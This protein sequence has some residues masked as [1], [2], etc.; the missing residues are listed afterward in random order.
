MAKYLPDPKNADNI[1]PSII[2]T[3]PT[4]V[5]KSTILEEQ[6]SDASPACTAQTISSQMRHLPYRPDIDG[7]RT[8]AV[9]LVVLFHAWPNWLRG[10]FIGVD[11]FFVIS[12]FLISSIILHDIDKGTYSITAFYSRRIRRIFPALIL[13]ISCTFAFGWFVMLR[14]EFTSLSKHSAS[15]AAFI[16]NLTYWEEAGYFDSDSTTKPL[17]HL[18]SLG[19]EEQFYILWPLFIW[20]LARWRKS[21]AKFIAIS[22][23]VSFIY[24]VYATSNTPSA[25]YF[26]PLSRFWELAAGGLCACTYSLDR[27]RAV[28]QGKLG[29]IMSIIGLALLA[30]A[31]WKV[32]NQT[33]FPGWWA[34]APVIGTCMLLQ[35]GGGTWIS[36]KLLARPMMVRLGLVSYPFY[37]WHWPLLSFSYIVGGERPTAMVKVGMVVAALA[38]AVLTYIAIERPVQRIQSRTN[39]V[40][41]L[42]VLMTAFGL[43]SCASYFGLLGPRQQNSGVDRYLKALNDVQFPTTQMTPIVYH[44]SHFQQLNG[45]GIGS[46][47]F[48]GDSVI[49]QYGAYATDLLRKEPHRRAKVLFATAG[50]C[51]PIEG[52]IRL[53]QLKFMHCAKTTENGMT[54]AMSSEVD[55]VVFGASWYGYFNPIYD[56]MIL[57]GHRFPSQEAHELAYQQIE[58]SLRRLVTAGK[59]VYFLM[60]PPSGS[61]FDPRSM[62]E[63]SRFAEMQV[64]K[65]LSPFN[66]DAYEQK[67]N[68]ARIR[69]ISLAKNSGA[70]IIY[71][72]DTLCNG[73]L[74]PVIDENGEPIYTDSVHIRPKFSINGARYLEPTLRSPQ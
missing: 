21:L 53:P 33:P 56:E 11:I 47:I 28:R 26:S 44:G 19:V 60:P 4:L 38:L 72:T 61:A 13:V 36:R 41:V 14:T 52:A 69:L 35:A 68:A 57:N 62:I 45:N 31:A 3:F 51:P 43:L 20:G 40:R 30:I 12:G 15:G 74:C 22:L 34:A 18:W 6:P 8:I 48:L 10:G 67:N 59:R 1:Q 54:L 49:E 23:V 50:G 39:I 29:E 66:L 55:S 65:S 17:L 2:A 32:T 25:A 24:S 7:M 70:V 63:G 9:F 71:P 27:V 42:V 16:A 64:R 73:S 5:T 46:T 58:R 37:L